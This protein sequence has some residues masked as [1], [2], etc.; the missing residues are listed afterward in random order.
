MLAKAPGV[1]TRLAWLGLVVWLALLVRPAYAQEGGGDADPGG[2]TIYIVQEGDTL[3]SIARRFG[4]SAEAIREA[5]S[6]VGFDDVSVGQRLIIPAAT[7]V[8][9]PFPGQELVVG[10]GETLYSV[11]VRQGVPVERLA[12]ANRVVNPVD[13]NAGQSLNVPP[14]EGWWPGG[15]VRVGEGEALWQVA[16]RLNENLYALMLA[17]EIVSPLLVTGGHLLAVTGEG[18]ADVSPGQP[19]ELVNLHPL[20]L[21]QGRVGSL[22]VRTDRPGTLAVT[23]M[24]REWDVATDGGAYYALLA[25][26]RLTAPGLYPLTLIFRD[27]NGGEATFSRQVLV[28]DGGYPSEEIKLADDVAAVLSQ[29]EAVQEEFLYIQQAMTGF[30]PDRLWRGRFLLPSPGVMTSGFGALRSY[31]GS[32]YNSYHTGSDLAGPAGTPIYAPADGIVVDT[33]LLDVRGYTTIID[34]GWGV[35]TG[36]WHQSAIHVK[37]GDRV[38]AGQLIGLV[39]STGLSTAAHLHWEMWVGGVRVDPMQW[40]RT[41]FP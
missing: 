22:V 40:V 24:G 7:S 20:P 19:W 10:L 28:V 21:E 17:N 26:D 6:L 37:P 13:L 5:N 32:G 30:N 35:Y 16:L 23:F 27:E 36:Y 34:H 33:G 39:G 25:I 14:P 3:H 2:V 31:N 38:T 8:F 12:A 11:A 29:P 1:A 4:V 18:Q 41:E 9:D 15:V